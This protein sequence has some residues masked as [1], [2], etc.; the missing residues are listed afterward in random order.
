MLFGMNNLE[1]FSGRGILTHKLMLHN[2]RCNSYEILEKD[3]V[4]L[5]MM[6]WQWESAHISMACQLKSSQKLTSRKKL[7]NVRYDSQQLLKKGWVVFSVISLPEKQFWQWASTH[8]SMAS[9]LKSSYFGQYLVVAL[10]N[11]VFKQS[12]TLIGVF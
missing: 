5:S 9:Q 12:R 8:I 3:Y 1:T 6:S 10:Q 7:H 11:S 2:V 4:V